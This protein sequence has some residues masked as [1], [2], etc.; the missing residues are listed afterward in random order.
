MP[1]VEVAVEWLGGILRLLVHI[2][3]EAVLEFLV[4]GLGYF[5][6]RL[7]SKSADRDGFVVVIVGVVS[8]SVVGVLFY[9]ASEYF[10]AQA[11]IDRCLDSSGSFK[12]SLQ[13]C[14]DPDV[15]RD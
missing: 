13:A 3:V 10:S 2:V 5:V 15:S 11:A 9:V 1:V 8:W 14:P 12:D 7:F 6:C 4:K